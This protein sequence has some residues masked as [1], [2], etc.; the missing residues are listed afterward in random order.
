MILFPIYFTKRKNKK[1]KKK[2]EYIVTTL[3]GFEPSQ[4][5]PN[6]PHK[7]LPVS[8]L[9][10][11]ELS[12][13]YQLSN[14]PRSVVDIEPIQIIKREEEKAEREEEKAEREE[15]KAERKEESQSQQQN[16]KKMKRKKKRRR[17]VNLV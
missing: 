8:Q 15:E 6:W 12:E 14:D 5:I 10:D 11:L 3:W 1:K 13:L 9:K 17:K 2:K 4:V 16:E 7:S